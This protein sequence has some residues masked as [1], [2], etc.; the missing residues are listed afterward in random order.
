MAKK[1]EN[2]KRK[3]SETL[4]MQKINLLS[5]HFLVSNKNTVFFMFIKAIHMF[6]PTTN[7]TFHLY[8]YVHIK[9]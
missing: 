8:L 4:K 9:F 7:N 5:F 6:M 1:R 2:E 3:I